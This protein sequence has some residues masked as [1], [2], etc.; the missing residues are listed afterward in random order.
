MP[1][2]PTSRARLALALAALCSPSAAAASWPEGTEAGQRA[3]H[4]PEPLDI[5]GVVAGSPVVVNHTIEG[6]S[7]KGERQ[8]WS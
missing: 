5:I 8:L 4:Q 6:R 2:V 3:G 1:V 7:S